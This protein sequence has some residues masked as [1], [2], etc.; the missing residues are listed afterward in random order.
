MFK[1]LIPWRRKR[2]KQAGNA[3]A[4][5]PN[6]PGLFPHWDDFGPWLD[7]FY[8]SGS[9]GDDQ[10]NNGWGCEVEDKEKEVVVRAEAPGFEPDEIEVQMSGSR[11]VLQAEHKEEKKEKN[12]HSTRYGSF[13]RTMT[14]PRGIKADGVQADYKNGVL[15]V[16][17][18]KGPDVQ[19]KRI[20]VKAK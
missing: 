5:T 4:S 17:L 20:S 6:F 1:N 18:P 10:W 2:E 19:S 13:Y 8:E 14:L 7:R 16:H 9:L 12:G 3:L 15:E 11:L